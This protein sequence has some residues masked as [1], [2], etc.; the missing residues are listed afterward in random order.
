MIMKFDHVR[1]MR[2][3]IFLFFYSL[4]NTGNMNHIT[5]STFFRRFSDQHCVCLWTQLQIT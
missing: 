5:T 3:I 1:Y 4:P 2:G